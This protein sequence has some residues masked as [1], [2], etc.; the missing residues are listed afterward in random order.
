MLEHLTFVFVTF[1][2]HICPLSLAYEE[3]KITI[4]LENAVFQSFLPPN[5]EKKQSP[6]KNEKM[7]SRSHFSTKSGFEAMKNQQIH[8]KTFLL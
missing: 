7:A 3:L 5:H 6:H 4:S 2:V 8:P 1:F